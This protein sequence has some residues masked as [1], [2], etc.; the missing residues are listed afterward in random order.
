MQVDYVSGI[1]IKSNRMWQVAADGGWMV[2]VD[3]RSSP[4]VR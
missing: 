3:D 4:R 1:K 2:A